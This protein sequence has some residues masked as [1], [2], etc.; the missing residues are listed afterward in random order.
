MPLAGLFQW[1]PQSD[2]M[3]SQIVHF[4]LDPKPQNKLNLNMAGKCDK[5]GGHPHIRQGML[6]WKRV[7]DL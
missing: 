2:A 1:P 3:P 6:V 5:F 4:F 7:E